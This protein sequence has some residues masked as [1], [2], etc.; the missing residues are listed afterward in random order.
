VLDI[1]ELTQIPY[2]MSLNNFT[3]MRELT[4]NTSFGLWKAGATLAQKAAS[5]VSK[6]D[7]YNASL[8]GDIM[9]FHS[10]YDLQ[11]VT[12]NAPQVLQ[13]YRMHAGYC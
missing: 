9:A 3:I 2:N 8:Q 4:R 6:A 13:S 7:A 12:T 5:L 11:W 10:N 1:T